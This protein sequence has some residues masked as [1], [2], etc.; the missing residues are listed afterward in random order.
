MR[1]SLPKKRKT[2][3]KDRRSE[4][5]KGLHDRRPH[6]HFGHSFHT[7]SI[8]RTDGRL[9]RFDLFRHRIFI[10]KGR[11][12]F[13]ALLF[14]IGLFFI[15]DWNV[16]TKIKVLGLGL[17]IFLMAILFTYEPSRPSLSWNARMNL[18]GPYVDP[19]F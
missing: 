8:Q 15:T 19:G 16:K 9:W 5:T 6:H 10:R 18:T 7:E 3:K 14:L 13:C 12:G 1:I 4:P 11:S 2:T 17:T